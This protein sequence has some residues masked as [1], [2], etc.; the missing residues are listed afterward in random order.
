MNFRFPRLIIIGFVTII[1]SAACAPKPTPPPVDNLA[2][3][4]ASG[5]SSV[6][7]LTAGAP[8]PLPSS[9]PLPPA[10][11][12]PASTPQPPTVRHHAACWFGPGSAYNLESNITKGE[13]VQILGVGSLPGWYI[14]RNPYFQQP[15]WIQAADL[16]IDPG[17]DLSQ[18]PV[19]TPYPLRTPKP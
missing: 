19:M 18:Y 13:S 17:M 15:C 6:L 1:L 16:N 9:T 4:V 8:T 2:T 5:V 11:I 12:T 14:I 3:N 7:T 10:T